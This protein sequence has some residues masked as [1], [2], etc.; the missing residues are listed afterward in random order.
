MLLE[1]Q[2]RTRGT[3]TG[4][5]YSE[6]GKNAYSTKWYEDP[7]LLVTLGAMLLLDQISKQLI[8]LNLNFYD[9]RASQ[10]TFRLTHTENS[11]AA[12]SLFP[13]LLPGIVLFSLI[14]AG[15][16]FYVFHIQTPPRR[17]DRL[18]VGLAVGRGGTWQPDRQGFPG[19]GRRL[20]I[21]W[22][23]SDL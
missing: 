11:E 5:S 18:A 9:L 8:R 15:L 7:L 23:V 16:Y 3:L 10:D 13:N 14:T 22:T 1:D 12:L 17:L 4:Y 20:R 6:V 21:G 2:D 19:C